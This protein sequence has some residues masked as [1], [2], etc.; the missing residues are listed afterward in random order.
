MLELKEPEVK[1]KVRDQRAIRKAL[2]EVQAAD[3]DKLLKPE[4]VV[5]EAEDENSPLHPY[6]TWDDDEASRQWRLHQ[7]RALIR[8][9]VVIMPDDKEEAAISKYV[10]LR[11][12]R[13]KPGGGYREIG[14]VFNS[15]EL[16]A[17]LEDTAK[18]D[19]DGVLRRYEMLKDFVAR[20][21]KAAGIPKKNK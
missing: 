18:R 10:S 14:Q 12:D 15:K 20:V 16:L 2:A 3:K 13:K 17:Q 8:H 4:D 5:K 1:V 11:N 9:I 19:V 6:F 7:A 21:R